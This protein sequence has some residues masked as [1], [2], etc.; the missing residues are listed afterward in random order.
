MIKDLDMVRLSWT[1][2]K[3]HHKC[4]HKRERGRLDKHSQGRKRCEDGGRDWSPVATS[5]EIPRKAGSHQMVEK[6]NNKFSTGVSS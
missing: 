5:Q 4:P 1:I 3:Y 6:A 2:H